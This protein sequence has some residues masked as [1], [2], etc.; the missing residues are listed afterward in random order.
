MV[1]NIGFV[2]KHKEIS[3]TTLRSLYKTNY[4]YVT[5]N[6]ARVHNLLK[7]YN[8]V[9]M[10]EIRVFR[11]DQVCILCAKPHIKIKQSGGENVEEEDTSLY[12][13]YGYFHSLRGKD[14]QG[15]N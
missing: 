7:E 9:Y 4:K 12:Q 11:F 1:Y 15:S 6:T 5:P 14:M 13:P 8:T 3:L 10:Y 2:N